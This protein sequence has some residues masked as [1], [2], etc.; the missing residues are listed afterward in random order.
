MTTTFE[1][2]IKKLEVKPQLETLQDVVVGIW[3]EISATCVETNKTEKKLERISAPDP[4]SDKFIDYSLLK[5]SDIIKWI[6]SSK[7][8]ESSKIRVQQM[9][10]YI[11]TP[12][13][14]IEIRTDFPWKS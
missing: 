12:K 11:P 4:G 1:I 6:T 3:Y 5:E 13:P 14:V 9:V 8:F 10:E 2:T 7:N